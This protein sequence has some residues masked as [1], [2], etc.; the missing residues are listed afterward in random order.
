MR[1]QELLAARQTIMSLMGQMALRYDAV[2][3][4]RLWKAMDQMR[5]RY[6][7]VFVGEAIRKDPSDAELALFRWAKAHEQ[8][9]EEEEPVRRER[10][11]KAPPRKKNTSH[12][13]A[14]LIG[15]LIL[16]FAGLMIV[17]SEEAVSRSDALIER[18]D[19]ILEGNTYGDE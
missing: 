4:K 19:R 13:I 7:D 3:M 1:Y 11:H 16:G 10:W 18:A 12:L 15:V 9:P 8:Q 14:M 6:G 2:T 17:E 5:A